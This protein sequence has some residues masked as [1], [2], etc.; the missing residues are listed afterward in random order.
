MK[1]SIDMIATATKTDKA[2]RV[3]DYC[4]FYEGLVGHLRDQPCSILEVGIRHGCSHAMWEIAF[5]K[6]KVFGVDIDLSA[7]TAPLARTVLIR[8]DVM[9]EG[10][11]QSVGTQFG[12]FDFAVDDAA[13]TPECSLKILGLFPDYIKPGGWLFIEDIAQGC[14]FK[15]FAKSLVD[16]VCH[17]REKVYSMD[18][19]MP[20]PRRWPATMPAFDRAIG[21]IVYGHGI[22]A[23]QRRA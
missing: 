18:T 10:F 2:S 16:R 23:I 7:C 9:D 6:A 21:R 4:N 12:P 11:I 13:H 22:V 14:E 20:R 15:E 19:A 3:H 17:Q 1:V 8:G 5:P